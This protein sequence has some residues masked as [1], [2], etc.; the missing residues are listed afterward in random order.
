MSNDLKSSVTQSLAVAVTS[1]FR[2]ASLLRHRTYQLRPYHYLTTPPA[3]AKVTPSIKRLSILMAIRLSTSNLE[4]STISDGLAALKYFTRH[5]NRGR[6]SV[7]AGTPAASAGCS[8][9]NSSPI[10]AVYRVSIESLHESSSGNTAK[11]SRAKCE[12]PFETV[13]GLSLMATI[14]PPRVGAVHH[15][16][17]IGSKIRL[18]L[19]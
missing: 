13:P 14:V 7:T 16:K 4:S 10:L 2:W 11:T 5:N 8:I 18:N 12:L 19:G 17:S 6:F 1:E 9:A 3:E 15:R